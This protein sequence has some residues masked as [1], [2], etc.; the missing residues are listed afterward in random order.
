MT[1]LSVLLL[2]GRAASTT[3][4]RQGCQYYC[5]R[6]DCQYCFMAGLPALLYG[7]A[8]SIALWQGCHCCY[9]LGQSLLLYSRTATTVIWQGSQR[10]ISIQW[11]SIRKMPLEFMIECGIRLLGLGI[12]QNTATLRRSEVWTSGNGTMRIQCSIIASRARR[13]AW[14][15]EACGKSGWC[16]QNANTTR[17]LTVKQ[18]RHAGA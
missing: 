6:Q 10:D 1:G 9:M 3:A 12:F 15:R 16:N 8:A 7:R 2:Y 17:Q 18:S 4:V 11:F 5:W 13:E 14:K